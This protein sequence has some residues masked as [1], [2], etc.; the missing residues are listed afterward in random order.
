MGF[1]AAYASRWPDAPRREDVHQGVTRIWLTPAQLL[2]IEPLLG[3]LGLSLDKRIAAR[4]ASD[5]VVGVPAE[6]GDS[7]IAAYEEHCRAF[8]CWTTQ[9]LEDFVKALAG[10]ESHAR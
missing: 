8:E 5:A 4:F 3:C 10:S 9:Q 7:V 1:R 2:E 6:Y